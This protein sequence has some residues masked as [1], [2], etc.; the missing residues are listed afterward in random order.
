MSRTIHSLGLQILTAGGLLGTSLIVPA[1]AHA[2]TGGQERALLNYTVA[3]AYVTG[4]VAFWAPAPGLARSGTDEG[5]RAL[6]GR[7]EAD[8]ASTPYREPTS[9]A[10]QVNAWPV[11]GERAL[12]GKRTEQ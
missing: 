11:N 10:S 6:L 2:Q 8:P 9:A 12:L 4:P 3:S 7:A 5:V 1:T